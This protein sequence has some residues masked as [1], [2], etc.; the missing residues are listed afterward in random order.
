MSKKMSQDVFIALA[1]IGW[2]DGKLDR[3]E[4]DGIV[5]AA[6]ESGLSIEEIE[7]IEKAVKESVSLK[8]IDRSKLTPVERTF[9][10]ACAVWLARLDGHVEPEEKMALHKLG[11]LLGMPDRVRTEASAAA[12]EIAQLEGGDRPDRYDF[13]KLQVRIEERLNAILAK[14][15][16]A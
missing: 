5:R 13:T 11:D 1:A 9:V 2:A 14:N 4:A 15:Q 16:T 12:L 10:Y 8:S 3:E 7:P 6:L